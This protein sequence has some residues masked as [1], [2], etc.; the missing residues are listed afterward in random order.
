MQDILDDLIKGLEH[1]NANFKDIGDALQAANKWLVIHEKR[2]K[3]LEKKKMSSWP[4][5]IISVAIF[6]ITVL[7]IRF[8]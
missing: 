7:G 3:K 5:I 6:W 8:S 2:L 1:H 4:I